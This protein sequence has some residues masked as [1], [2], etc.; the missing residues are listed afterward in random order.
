MRSETVPTWSTMFF[1]TITDFFITFTASFLSFWFFLWQRK[2]LPKA[3]LEIG[4]K[5]SKSSIEGA[6]LVLEEGLDDL[7]KT[8]VKYVIQMK[9]KSEWFEVSCFA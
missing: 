5:I 6:M 4:F 8:R 9:S 2:T 7:Q 3:P 1:C